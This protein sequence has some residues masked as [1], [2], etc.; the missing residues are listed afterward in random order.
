MNADV[1]PVID[2]QQVDESAHTDTAGTASRVARPSVVIVAALAAVA[3]VL[4]GVDLGLHLIRPG[5]DPLA[6][7]RTDA[8]QNAKVRVPKM[9]TYAYGSIDN[10]ITTASEQLTGNF[11]KEYTDLLISRVKPGALAG[12]IST[13]A[14]A[15]DAGVV[16]AKS[17]KVVVLVFLNLTTT[18]GP[19][20]VTQLNGSRVEVTM[21][22]VGDDWLVSELKP[23]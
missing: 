23:V 10:D 3:L 12:K 18:S 1:D 16:S 5:A 20:A 22:K 9:L 8:L 2:D 11:K 7:S 14:A 19:K 15:V 21:T 4:G 6:S 17:D 13:K